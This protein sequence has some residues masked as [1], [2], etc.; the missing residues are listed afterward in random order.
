MWNAVIEVLKITL[1]FITKIIEAKFIPTSKEFLY[2]N[3]D[4]GVDAVIKSLAELKDKIAKSNNEFDNMGFQLGID[5]LKA[6][7]EKI[8]KAVEVLES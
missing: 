2:K 4:A 1:P 6:T 7:A 3:L 8:V 5:V